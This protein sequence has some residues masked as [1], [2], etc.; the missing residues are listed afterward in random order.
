LHLIP[1]PQVA[2]IRSTCL[3]ASL[4]HKGESK[5]IYL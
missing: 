3:H 1:T 5:V 2:H 4:Y